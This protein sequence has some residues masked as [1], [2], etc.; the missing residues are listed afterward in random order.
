MFK[1]SKKSLAKLNKVNPDLQKLVKSAIGLSTIDFGISE[2]MRTKERQQI[3]YDTGKS[4]TMNSRHLT[5]HAVDVY[6]WKDGAVSWEFEDYETI[7][8]AFSQAAKLT[9]T[10]YVWGG[11]WKTF[12]DGPHFELKREK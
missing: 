8:V 1:L 12:K 7:N 9:N 5:G 4:Q 3:L 6:A 11:S 10:P 2:G